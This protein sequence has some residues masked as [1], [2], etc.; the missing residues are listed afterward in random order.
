MYLASHFHDLDP[1]CF[2]LVDVLLD[3]RDGLVKVDVLLCKFVDV[4]LQVLDQLEPLLELDGSLAHLAIDVSELVGSEY[5]VGVVGVVLLPE[6]CE[7][8]STSGHIKYI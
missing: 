8:L 7:L 4:A 3:A 6:V 2:N 5:P 1:K